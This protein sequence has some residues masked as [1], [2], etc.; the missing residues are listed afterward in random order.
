VQ[1]KAGKPAF[2]FVR[3]LRKSAALMSPYPLLQRIFIF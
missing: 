3:L 2:F 1:K